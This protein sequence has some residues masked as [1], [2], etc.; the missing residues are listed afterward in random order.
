[1]AIDA[2]RLLLRFVLDVNARELLEHRD[3]LRLLLESLER[4]REQ[5][6]RLDVARIRLEARL[7]LLQRAPRIVSPQVQPGELA[8]QRV[9]I[10]LVPQ[11][12]FGDLDEIVLAALAPQLLARDRELGRRV[13]DETFLRVQLGELD[14]CRDIFGIEIDELLDRRE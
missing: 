10:R 12:T 4:L 2:R 7:E 14:P 8:I 9:I 11:Q 5:A 6:E 3:G 13:V 1:L